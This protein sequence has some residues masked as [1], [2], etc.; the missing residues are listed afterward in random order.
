VEQQEQHIGE[1]G[2]Y[3]KDEVQLLQL[4]HLPKEKLSEV[5]ED[6]LLVQLLQG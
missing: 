3:V 1:E 4:L 5:V 2:E 6:Q